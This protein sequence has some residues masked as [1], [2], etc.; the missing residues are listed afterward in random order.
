MNLRQKNK[1]LKQELERLKDVA[2]KPK[3]IDRS[4]E[5]VECIQ[6]QIIRLDHL[7]LAPIIPPLEYMKN[8]L[9]HMISRDISDY[10]QYECV[11]PGGYH[12]E[13]NEENFARCR[14]IVAKLCVVDRRK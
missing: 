11:M 8:E 4:N 1:K 14:G 3:Y 2:I 12:D 10:I 5:R 13:L 7:M 6:A 9:L